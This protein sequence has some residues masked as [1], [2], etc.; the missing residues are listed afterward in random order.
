MGGILYWIIIGL[1]A[2]FITGKVMG[3]PSNDLLMTIITGIAGAVVGG[4]LMTLLGFSYTGNLVYNVVVAVLG[5]VLL[6]WGYHK[7]K[8]RT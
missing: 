3:T 4:F 2:G 5:A 7:L 8:A 1:I 6:T